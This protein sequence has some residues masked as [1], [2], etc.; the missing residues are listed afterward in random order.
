MARLLF[1]GMWNFCDDA[2]IHPASAKTLK[3]EIFP[4]DDIVSVD[5]QK[6]VDELIANELL[7]EYEISGKRY[8]K[9][10]GW[11]HQRIEKPNFKHPKPTI[12]RPFDDHSATDPQPFDDHSTTE[13]KGEGEEKEK[14]KSV[15]PAQAISTSTG[16]AQAAPV[17][18]AADPQTAFPPSTT[19][20]GE[21]CRRLKLLGYGDT[22]PHD[23]K[24]KA[25]L[26]SGLTADEL[27][28]VGEEARGRGKGF[29]WIIAAAEGRRREAANVTPLPAK[30]AA[31]NLSKAGQKTAEAAAR[32]LASQG[33]QQA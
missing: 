24:L 17:A 29:R 25:L 31:G 23:L 9:V 3:A 13:R 1:I 15:N 2:G 32:W 16:V 10:T 18:C 6:L 33:V 12:R 27:I 5:V 14:E 4:A 20:T 7:A 11:H 21:V 26:A 19:D 28:A 30:A 8:W 22:N